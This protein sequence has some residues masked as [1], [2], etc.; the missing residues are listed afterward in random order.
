[1]AAKHLNYI[2]HILED[3]LTDVRH[4]ESMVEHHTKMSENDDLYEQG[5]K[6]ALKR[7][8]TATGNLAYLKTIEE[9]ARL[10]LEHYSL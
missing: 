4:E 9:A 6:D 10:I 2:N 5:K 3:V 8:A 7:L 1:M